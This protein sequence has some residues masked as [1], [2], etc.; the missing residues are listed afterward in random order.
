MSSAQ[1]CCQDCGRTDVAL[2]RHHL[3]YFT[4]AGYRGPD[5]PGGESIYGLETDEDLALLCRDCHHQRHRDPD[6][7]FWRDPQDMADA[8]L[9]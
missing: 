5:D 8:W 1:R 7:V 2:E 4:Q 3:R 6:G 9:G